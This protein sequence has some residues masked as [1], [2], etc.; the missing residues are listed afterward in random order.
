LLSLSLSLSRSLSRSLLRSLSLSLPRSLLRS[1][2]LSL[3]L[4][5]ITRKSLKRFLREADRIGEFPAT[6]LFAL[7]RFGFRFAAL[8][9]FREQIEEPAKREL[10][11]LRAGEPL[12]HELGLLDGAGRPLPIHPR[13]AWEKMARWLDDDE[14]I[15][16]FTFPEGLPAEVDILR[17]DLAQLRK[18]PWSPQAGVRAL[19]ED[20]PKEERERPYT[21]EAADREL[22]AACEEALAE[23]Q[24][25]RP[26][27]S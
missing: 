6:P 23:M 15:L 10:R 14:A 2:S 8:D 19:L 4:T 26:R 9:W 17:A 25:S 3:P 20:W 21:L 18:Q 24:K 11:G 7:A 1:R 5:D 27:K 16:A 13:A 22:R 12:P